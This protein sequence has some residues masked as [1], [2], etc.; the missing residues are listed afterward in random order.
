MK[1]TSLIM[2]VLLL[3][4]SL[5]MVQFVSLAE[6]EIAEDETEID[7]SDVELLDPSILE[8]F[9]LSDIE[10]LDYSEFEGLEYEELERTLVPATEADQLEGVQVDYV[11]SN[12]TFA[13]HIE[14]MA[15]YY[16]EFMGKNMLLIGYVLRYDEGEE[17]PDADTNFAIARDYEM[18]AHEHA[19]GEVVDHEDVFPVGI[20][21]RYTGELLA[22]GTWVRCVGVL[23][24]YN[25]TMDGETFEALRL[26]IVHM[27]QI[28]ESIGGSRTVTE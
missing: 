17:T 12:T 4:L 27:E 15:T 10:E 14:E 19:E 26:N 3:V 8:G 23:E 2:L 20:D 13:T 7:L 9:D 18:P 1:K 5:C 28:D 22:N 25:A 16:D 11:I 6:T 21:C 24:E